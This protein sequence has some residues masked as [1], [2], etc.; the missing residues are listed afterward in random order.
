MLLFHKDNE[1]ETLVHV[2]LPSPVNSTVRIL[3]ALT[4]PINAAKIEV[5]LGM[6]TMCIDVHKMRIILKISLNI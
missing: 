5:S 6:N 4:L 2:V 1:W 3:D